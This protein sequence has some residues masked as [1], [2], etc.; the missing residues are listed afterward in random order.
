MSSTTKH[1]LRL[2]L[3]ALILVALSVLAAG[4]GS[5]AP[6][7][8]A[9]TTTPSSAPSF[10]D[11]VAKVKTGVIRIEVSPSCA[12]THATT[13]RLLRPPESLASAKILLRHARED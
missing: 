13:R 5:S 11:V 10:A 7:T 6:K 9:T 8:L 3:G 2:V 12:T 1:S 4:C